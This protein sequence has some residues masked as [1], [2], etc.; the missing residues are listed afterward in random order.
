MYV[1][2]GLEVMKKILKC[3]GCTK[4]NSKKFF[5]FFFTPLIDVETFSKTFLNSNFFLITC[6]PEIL[7]IF[8]LN[9][10]KPHKRPK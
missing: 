10:H 1:K 7:V 3:K 4:K 8:V 5:I 6:I 2:L 9:A